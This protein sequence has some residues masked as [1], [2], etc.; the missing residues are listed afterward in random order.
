MRTRRPSADTVSRVLSQFALFVVC[1]ALCGTAC[2]TPSD[3]VLVQCFGMLRCTTGYCIVAIS[4]VVFH[5]RCGP[6]HSLK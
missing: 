3:A 6:E 4:A 2:V 5:E 1:V